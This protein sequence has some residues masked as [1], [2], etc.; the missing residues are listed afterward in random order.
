MFR[1]RLPLFS[2]LRYGASQFPLIPRR[3]PR[4]SRNVSSIANER[5]PRSSLWPRRLLY[6]GI[7]GGLGYL[8]VNLV[9]KFMN[10]PFSLPGSMMEKLLSESSRQAFEHKLRIVREL[11]EHPDWVE[12][13]VYGNFS[14]NEKDERLTSGPLGGLPG[15]HLQVRVSITGH[16]L[17]FPR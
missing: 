5:T 17:L 14:E 16:A 1:P 6:A 15:L 3:L 10:L 2:G 4:S 12:G 11:R 7:F 13:S 9:I 8:T